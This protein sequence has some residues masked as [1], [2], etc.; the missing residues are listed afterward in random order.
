MG[1]KLESLDKV[2]VK[3]AGD[4]GDG[5][6]VMGDQFGNATAVVG[7]DFATLPDYPAEIRA[8][9]GTTYGVSSYQIQFAAYD[10]YTPGDIPD[11]LVAFNPAALKVNLTSLKP[12]GTIIANEDEFTEQNLRKVGFSSNPLEDDSLGSFRVYRVPI[13]R[14]TIESLKDEPVGHKDKERC[15]NFFALGMM[16]WLFSR[17]LEPSIEFLKKRFATKVQVMEANI[18][19]LKAGYN[20]CDTMEIFPIHYQLPPAKLEPGKYRN[21]NGAFASACGLVVASHKSGL[22]LIY[23]GYPITPASE[24]LEVL[25]ALK[26][27]G[28]VTIQSE[29]EISAITM[30]IGA[31]YSGAIGVTG[32]SGPG[33]AL[34]TE[35]LNLAVMT[36]LPLIVFDFQRSG[37]STGMPT[38]TEQTDLLFALFGRPAESPVIILAPSSPADCFWISIEAVRLATKYMTPVIVLSEQFLVH[39]SEPWKLPDLDKIPPIE[40][41][42]RTDPKGFYP[43]MRDEKTLARPWVKLGTPG[44]EHTLGGLEKSNIQGTISYEPENHDLMN[45]LRAQKIQ[46]VA[47]DIPDAQIMGPADADVVV[48][49]WGGTYGHIKAAIEMANQDGMKVAMVHLRYLNPLQKNLGDLLRRFKK[50]LVPELNLGQL[51]YVLRAKYLIDAIGY[52]RI[53]G[54]PFYV[55]ELLNFIKDEYKSLRMH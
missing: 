2:T 15:R 40:V 3:F 5:V 24:T 33:L 12:G 16:C 18:K 39:S 10:V 44:L 49:G 48:V 38:K 7:N 17:P 13:T 21:V 51:S 30:A 42:F 45:K 1:K 20:I 8:P 25:A 46:K 14:L 54:R 19:A 9:Q 27:Y 52:N 34:K 22:P 35:A 55:S 4:S 29:D 37:P 31:A 50:V 41:N 28:A 53:T 26:Q 36:E 11:V 43:Y 32:T 6:Q 23:S 47:Q